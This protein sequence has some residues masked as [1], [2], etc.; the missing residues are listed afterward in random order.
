M[1]DV[2]AHQLDGGL[3]R[4]YARG[5]RSGGTDKAG[6]AARVRNRGV[7]VE[8][9]RAPE[10]EVEER[11]RP[12]RAECGLIAQESQRGDR[13]VIERLLESDQLADRQA[14]QGRPGR[15]RRDLERAVLDRQRAAGRPGIH[16]LGVG[17]ERAARTLRCCRPGTFSGATQ[18]DGAQEN[19]VRQ[20][21][22]AHELCDRA[23][24]DTP[25]VIHLEKALA[26]VRPALQEI[27]IVLVVRA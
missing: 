22:R 20:A 14:V 1:L 2:L 18:A 8:A 3:A 4:V 12:R 11:V 16:A 15:D 25:E 13:I 17:C 7:G 10:V 5:R 26:S 24:R 19:V 23:T 9:R 27:E 6:G 21:R